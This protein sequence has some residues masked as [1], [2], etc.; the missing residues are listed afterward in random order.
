[1]RRLEGMGQLGFGLDCILRSGR[2]R[3]AVEAKLFLE[4]DPHELLVGAR[5]LEVY[6]SDNGMGWMLRLAG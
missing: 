4:A 6:L 3:R 2:K 1:M 5:R